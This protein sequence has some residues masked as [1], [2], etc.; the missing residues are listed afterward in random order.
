MLQKIQGENEE[1]LEINIDYS[2]L[3]K[4]NSAVEEIDDLAS[5]ID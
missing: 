4:E 2:K 5:Q 1:D 3:P